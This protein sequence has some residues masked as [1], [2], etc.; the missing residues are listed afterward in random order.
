[1]A[2]INSPPTRRPILSSAVT[3]KLQQIL[4]QVCSILFLFVA[5][6][7]FLIMISYHVGDPSF[8]S[9]TTEV[10]RNFL[11]TLGSHLADPLHLALGESYKLILFFMIAWSWRF[12]FH[13]KKRRKIS[14]LI[15]LPLPLATF[16]IF[17][18]TNPHL[19]DGYFP[20]V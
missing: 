6:S 17:L 13:A 20:T 14:R 11:G 2:V 19:K 10:P 4:Y 16:S 3:I 7:I 15:F 9:A 5:I 12:A 18:A 8:R 1:M